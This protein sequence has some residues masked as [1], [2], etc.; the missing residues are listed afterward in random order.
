MKLLRELVRLGRTLPPRLLETLATA[1]ERLP[2][3][4]KT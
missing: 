3:L 4:H 1:L 2:E